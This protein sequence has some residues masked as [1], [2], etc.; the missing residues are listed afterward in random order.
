MADDEKTAP[1]EQKQAPKKVAAPILGAKLVTLN[2]D[3]SSA[4][5]LIY[6]GPV[7]K[8]GTKLLATLDNGVT[9][10]GIVADATEADGEVLVEFRD[11][12]K[13]QIEPRPKAEPEPPAQPKL[14]PTPLQPDVTSI[15]PTIVPE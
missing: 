10:A 12:L 13:P 15:T 4:P 2:T 11:G 6:R 8:V 3:G 1:A 9:Y 5:A 14:K 7:P